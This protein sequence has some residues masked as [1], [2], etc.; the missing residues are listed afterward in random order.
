VLNDGKN[1]YLYDGEGR[2]CAVDANYSVS[3]SYTQYIYDAGGA[4]VAKGSLTSWPSSCGAPGTNGFALTNQYLLDQGG[5]QVTE[6]NGTGGWMHSNVWAGAHLDATYDTNGLHFHLADP[7][8]TRRV[9]ANV[10]GVIEENFQSLPFGDGLTPVAN[11][12]CLTA[13][14]CYAEDATEHHFTGKERD[15]ESGNDYFFAR[16]YSSSMGRFM[17]PDWSAKEEPVPYANLGNPQSLNLYAYVLNNPLRLVDPDGHIDCSGDNGKGAGCQAIADRNNRQGADADTWR[18]SGFN[19]LTDNKGNVVQGASGGA[20]LLPKGFDV[21]KVLEA[22]RVDAAMSVVSPTLSA[23]A[24]ANDLAKFRR[25]GQWDLQRLSGNF[26]PNFIDS[27][28]ILIG[29]YA[30]SAGIARGEILSIQNFVAKG[31]KYAKD[32]PMDSTY[33]HLP[34]RNVTNTDIGMRLVQS[35]E[36]SIP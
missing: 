31:S 14:H 30:S 26:N 27:A 5:D 20:A 35:G 12:N 7:L 24:T 9:Q 6:L 29:M 15:A 16:Y 22:G 33:T 17:S 1:A 8:G 34:V 25:G 10:Y 3:P 19:P 28:T 4:R 32:T 21:S 18:R 11:P 23:A 36:I 13:N 2:L